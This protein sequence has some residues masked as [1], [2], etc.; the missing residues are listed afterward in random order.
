MTLDFINAVV[1]NGITLTLASYDGTLV[2]IDLSGE[3]VI[4]SKR[5]FDLNDAAGYI[6]AAIDEAP[7]VAERIKQE[8]RE[9]L[10]KPAA[11]ANKP[12]EKKEPGPRS[13]YGKARRD[14]EYLE[15]LFKLPD[16]VEIDSCMDDF[17]QNP[18]VEYATGLYTSKIELWFSQVPRGWQMALGDERN[19]AMEMELTPK[20]REIADRWG[21]DISGWE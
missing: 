2:W 4:Y 14:F 18:T 6:V 9:A 19:R 12:K 10:E 5:I 17:M 20:L 21:A 11:K 13:R 1:R 15:T 7:G 8:V 3:G 16:Q